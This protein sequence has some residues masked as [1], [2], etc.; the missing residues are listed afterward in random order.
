[1]KQN[2]GQS[3]KKVNLSDL[4]MPL[5]NFHERFKTGTLEPQLKE[6]TNRALKKAFENSTYMEEVRK[7]FLNCH[8]PQALRTYKIT[9]TCR[10]SLNLSNK[11]S[12]D[13]FNINC[14]NPYIQA[15][16]GKFIRVAFSSAIGK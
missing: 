3:S 6:Q 2:A 14:T 16:F 10:G 7:V 8:Y 9:G 5:A 15:S 4:A 11:G 1:G 12:L 13:S